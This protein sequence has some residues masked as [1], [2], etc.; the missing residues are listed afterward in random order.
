MAYSD[1][2]FPVL[3]KNM[4]LGAST[5]DGGG[6]FLCSKDGS[7]TVTYSDNATDTLVCVVGD[8]YDIRYKVK[9]VQIVSGEFHLA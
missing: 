4:N 1:N 5:I 9:T 7:L 8:A 2:A 3:N 6:V